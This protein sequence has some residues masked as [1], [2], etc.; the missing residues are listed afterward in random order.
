M[1]NSKKEQEIFA[2]EPINRGIIPLETFKP[3]KS[4]KRELNKNIFEITVNKAFKDVMKACAN[5]DETWINGTIFELYNELFKIKK[6]HS[7]EVWFNDQLVGGLYGVS[8]KGAFF[9]ESMFSIMKNTS[10]IALFHLVNLLN[11]KGFILLD[12]QFLTPHLASLGGI[13]ISQKK[14]LKLLKEALNLKDLELP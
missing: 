3:S 10:K 6:A 14:Y 8:H 9:G 7:I 12:T 13:E 11:K 2:V 1:A 4:L 5:R